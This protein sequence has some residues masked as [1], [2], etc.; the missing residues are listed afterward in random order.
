MPAEN[1]SSEPAVPSWINGSFIQKA[2][3]TAE[4]KHLKVLRVAVSAALA[5][6]ENYLSTLYRV[7]AV[8]EDGTQRSL[9]VKIP[10]PGEALANLCNKNGYFNREA[11]MMANVVPKL[12]VRNEDLP[13]YRKFLDS[14]IRILDIYIAKPDILTDEDSVDEDKGGTVDNLTGR[15]RLA[16]TEIRFTKEKLV[17][18]DFDK[19]Q[20]THTWIE[21]DFENTEKAFP[22]SNYSYFSDKSHLSHVASP[23]LDILYFLSTSPSAEVSEFHEDL[24]LREYYAE[25]QRTMDLLGMQVF[26]HAST[27]EHTEGCM[28]E[29]IQET[30]TKRVDQKGTYSTHKKTYRGEKYDQHSQTTK[31]Q[32]Q[33]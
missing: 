23:V 30:I 20:G 15:Q 19:F 25:L 27:H 5:S 29:H 28:R 8:L 17:D 33:P 22:F 7:K 11:V 12:E 13:P 18:T 26:S 2:L 9:V 31:A 32:Q 4:D 3:Q 14:K 24:L 1:I 16:D 21:E 6:G 10:P